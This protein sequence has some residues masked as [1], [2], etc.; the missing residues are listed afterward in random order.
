MRTMR[1]LALLIFSSMIISTC[2]AGA[3]E[4]IGTVTQPLVAGN[5]VSAQEQLD[6]VLVRVGSC[7]GALL[8][9]EW[10]ISAVHCFVGRS[11]ADIVV[12]AEWP[13][14]EERQASELHRLAKD[15]ALVRVDRPF[16]GI[17][18]DFNMPVYIGDILPGR[19][20]RVYG[21]GVYA[22]ATGK[23][24]SAQP[25]R[26][27]RKWRV[28]EFTVSH[29][30]ADRFWF[31]PNEKGQIP[32]G[33]DS[34][35]PA[36]I[37]AGNQWFFAGVSSLCMKFSVEGKPQNT[38]EWV[39]KVVE[40]G[41]AP[42]ADVWADIQ[43]LTGTQGCRKYAWRAI[44]AVSYAQYHGCDPAV[45]SG[46]RWSPRFDDH[47]NWCMSVPAA[48]A[49]AEDKERNR[50][51]HECRLAAAMPQ[52][53]G[54]LTVAETP[55]GFALSGGGYP[56]NSRIIIRVKGPAAV[57]Q[58]ITSNFSDPQGNFSAQLSAAQVCATA[59]TVTFTAEDQDRPP[60]PPVS[61]TCKSA[62]VAGTAV[63]APAP[64]QPQPQPEAQPLVKFVGV[65]LD[66]D[67]YDVPGGGGQVVGM[68]RAGT[69]GVRLRQPCAD[70]WCSVI[71]PGGQGWVYSGPGYQSLRLP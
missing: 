50:I 35:G 12:R 28:A 8:N 20:V 43:R 24:A 17:S 2:G 44:G 16:S 22:L 4:K 68:L 70:G 57:E 53:T 23:G 31:P 66:V 60:S 9:S 29:V 21:A 52:G 34:G 54:Q 45:I 41:Y 36:F 47:L 58:N 15:V 25:S 56:V 6:Q 7:S 3:A 71:W 67:L 13:T 37:N 39:N 61:M 38:W 1:L 30:D 64:I 55:D 46:P 32:A 49:N 14:P 63:P 26:N 42:L 5:E 18:P 19:R 59:G 69:R 27:D 65:A 40:C 51:M 62:Q 10:A 48:T 11:A 33:G